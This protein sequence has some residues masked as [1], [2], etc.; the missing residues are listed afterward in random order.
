MAFFGRRGSSLF[1]Y[2]IINSGLFQE[3]SSFYIR[4]PNILSDHFLLE[5]LLFAKHFIERN[6]IEKD[7]DFINRVYKWDKCLKDMY[8]ESVSSATFRNS[9]FDLTHTIRNADSKMDVDVSLSLFIAA[10]DKV[11]CPLFG[12]AILSQ[13]ILVKL[14]QNKIPY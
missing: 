4:D 8:I 12:K 13:T 2:C 6:D 3:F 5:I 10:S 14:S 11:C 1:D 7:H 9:L